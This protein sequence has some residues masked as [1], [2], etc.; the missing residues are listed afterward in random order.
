MKKSTQLKKLIEGPE[1]LLMPGAFDPLSAKIA[2]EAGFKAVQCTGMGISATYLGKPDVSII[3]L[4]EMADRTYHIASAVDIPVMADADTG[5][6]NAVNAYYTAQEF[7][8]SGAAGLNIEDQ[9]MPK[10]CGWLAGKEIIP[11]EE[12]V[13]KIQAMREGLTDP[14]FVINARTDSLVLEGLDGAIR[15]SNAYLKAGGTMAFV[16]SATTEEQIKTLVAGIDGPVGLAL[17]ESRISP[18]LNFAR[19]QELGVARV[20]FSVTTLLASIRAMRNVLQAVIR[21]GGVSGYDDQIAEFEAIHQ[22]SGM[23]TVYDIEKKYLQSS[24]IE[25]KYKERA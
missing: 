17:S 15:R 25:R 3:S 13:L 2:A 5:F 14:D 4:R 18:D 20:S 9:V 11:L 10:R 24:E 7:E 22:L 23:N 16:E 12:M 1:L 8:R 21:N 19:L 6:G